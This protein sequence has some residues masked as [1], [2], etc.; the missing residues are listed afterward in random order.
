V[1]FFPPNP[2]LMLSAARGFAK[3]KAIDPL[4]NLAKRRIYVFS[5]TDDSVVRQPAV[6]ATAGFFQQAGVPAGN[7]LYEHSLPAGHAVI[8]PGYGNDCA[9]NAAPYISHCSVDGHGYDQAGALLAHVYGPLKPRIDKPAGRIVPFDQRP[10]AK[11]ATAMADTGSLYVPAA[12]TALEAHC[13]VHVAIHG[14][15]QS[16][17]SVGAQ[18][19]TDTGYNAWADANAI[20]VL[21]PQ[22]DKST[23]PFNPQGCWDWWGYT[24]PAYAQKSAPQMKAIMAMVARL[25]Q[26]K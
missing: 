9:A 20:L 11:A 12:C 15:L 25:T 19:T 24:G 10:F 6:D 22:V 14:C 21:Y 16:V 8:T 3:A 23:V 26:A 4:E 1:P 17:Q 5:G 7:L 18:F 2:A 13:K